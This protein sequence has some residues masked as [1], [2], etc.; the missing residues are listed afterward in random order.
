MESVLG[1]VQA[2]KMPFSLTNVPPKKAPM[3]PISSIGPACTLRKVRTYGLITRELLG[4]RL[5]KFQGVIFK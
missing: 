5:R 1:G 2:K 4:L 3:H